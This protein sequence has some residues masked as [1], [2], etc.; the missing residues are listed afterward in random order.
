MCP[1]RGKV[2]EIKQIEIKGKDQSVITK[3][4]NVTSKGDR[5]RFYD[6]KSFDNATNKMELPTFVDYSLTG[7]DL[8]ERMDAQWA[9]LT[10]QRTKDDKQI[11]RLHNAVRRT[12]DGKGDLVKQERFAD[13][14][15]ALD[16]GLD[17][18]LSTNRRI[19]EMRYGELNEFVRL[20]RERQDERYRELLTSQQSRIAFP[21]SI[22]LLG[23]IGYTFAVRSSIRSLVIEFG[24]ALASIIGYYALIGA[25][26]VIAQKTQFA[27]GPMSWLTT[28]IFAVILI[29][30]F[31]ELERVPR[32]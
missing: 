30:R 17:R 3:N 1:L 29:M 15:I 26:Q 7:G 4:K 13:L 32:G 2:T 12:F 19:N 20:H 10:T 24:L 9:I 22:F 16:E 5:N 27:V 31:W 11:W 8:L 25:S 28:V 21:F 18:F 14:E 23:M 6:M